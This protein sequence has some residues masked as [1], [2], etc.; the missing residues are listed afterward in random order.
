M[1]EHSDTFGR[2]KL[3]SLLQEGLLAQTY[4]ATD[5]ASGATVLLH[6]VRT[7]ASA[8]PRL[9][10]ALSEWE[11][12]K[13]YLP[14]HPNILKPHDFG[15]AQGHCYYATEFPGGPALDEAFWAGPLDMQKGVGILSQIAEGLQAAHIQ[16]V[17]HGDVKPASIFLA[18]AQPGQPTVKVCFFD[19][20]TATADAGV[21]IFGELAGTPKYLAPELVMGRR[22]DPRADIYA[23]GVIAYQMFTSREPFNAENAL[24][25]LHANA[26]DAP[27][28]PEQANALIPDSLAA[29]V[30]RLLEKRP[31]DRYQSCQALLDDLG[32]CT[33][34]VSTGRRALL[35][36]GTDSAFAAKPKPRPRRRI[37]A[38]VPMAL[39]AAIVIVAAAALWL[40]ANG[41]QGRAGTSRRFED[42]IAMEYSG[43]HESA[44]TAYDEIATKHVGTPWEQRAQERMQE[45]KRKLATDQARRVFEQALT[46]E[47]SERYEEAAGLYDKVATEHANTHWAELAQRRKELIQRRIAGDEA[48]RLFEQALESEY[49]KRADAASQQYQELIAKHPDSSW[50]KLA[51]QRPG[52]LRAEGD[53]REAMQGADAAVAKADYSL[54]VSLYMTFRNSH[55]TSNYVAEAGRRI[56]QLRLAAAELNLKQGKLK[57]AVEELSKLASQAVDQDVAARA[58]SLQPEAMFSYAEKLFQG[59]SYA[60]AFAEL[61]E[62]AKHP[63]ADEWTKKAGDLLAPCDMLKDGQLPEAVERLH[64]LTSE[65][66][67]PEWAGR[68]A[69]WLDGAVSHW[70]ERLIEQQKFE[71]ALGI[72]S[73]R[74]PFEKGRDES[75]ARVLYEWHTHL[76]KLDR[77]DQAREKGDLLL[78][79][80][81]QTT[82][83]ER[84]RELR[85]KEE[86]EKKRITDKDQG[87]G[88]PP[89]KLWAEAQ[90]LRRAY[91]RTRAERDFKT[92]V[93]KLDVLARKWPADRL[94]Q[95]ARDL[96]PQEVYRR[97]LWL[98]GIGKRD[99]GLALFRRLQEELARSESATKAQAHIDAMAGTPPG[100]TYVPA[101][102]AF[103]IGI[104]EGDLKRILAELYGGDA[105]GGMLA[106]YLPET[107]LRLV[108]TSVTPFYID[109]AE[110]SVREY[111]RFVEATDHPWRSR[112]CDRRSGHDEMPMVEVTWDDAMAYA[113][114]AGKR[115][116]SEAE[117]ELAAKG[118]DGRAW[119]WGAKF[120]RSKC[121]MVLTKGDRQR[122]TIMPAK[123][124]PDGVSPYGCHDMSGN[125][126]E[127]TSSPYLRY[128]DSRWE[129]AAQDREH[130]V[131]RG[132]T[133]GSKAADVRTT[134]RCGKQPA[135]PYETVGFRCA[136]SIGAARPR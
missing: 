122:P 118:L 130:R 57:E 92:Y 108:E 51:R 115:L 27:I 80:Y 77:K 24:G 53:W 30:L 114:W 73:K 71:Q 31:E 93:E 95:H 33:R 26:Y 84:I 111:R 7:E 81:P 22:P 40:L 6:I 69:N 75:S 15:S 34:Q 39:G 50:A 133:C 64:K 136:K 132:G 100:M 4:E 126:A 28:P 94:G 23:L 14:E 42:A 55:P 97:G 83:A 47:P 79:R 88:P 116:P 89:G 61:S 121:N 54:A 119:P 63:N 46:L 52:A 65:Y 48:R 58:R 102:E 25:Y 68:A 82:W 3:V 29:V 36:A 35:P 106:S 18:G 117:W 8:H 103:Q 90:E 128:P 32:R 37:R 20:A 11:A 44:L 49:F 131:C 66:R 72:L 21:T 62:A 105:A 104:N 85:K 2:F 110:V 43:H 12:T 38:R 107:P 59:R 78:A 129:P 19:L 60:A 16:G 86:E 101:P 1:S 99:D 10:H 67:E 98:A 120:D 5:T 13:E 135:K 9:Q 17:V 127:W 56:H 112:I 70:V 124:F 87:E 109:Q 45:I 125:V 96:V 76:R 41:T 134:Y 74:A 123:S 113:A 91:E